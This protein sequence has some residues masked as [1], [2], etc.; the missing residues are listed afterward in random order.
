MDRLVDAGFACLGC[1]TGL[2]LNWAI[3]TEEMVR[4][5]RQGREMFNRSPPEYED[6]IAII[7]YFK[8]QDW[9]ILILELL[10]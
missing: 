2:R 8:A 9:V 3:I 6:E 1:V 10:V 4:D 7:E 5:M